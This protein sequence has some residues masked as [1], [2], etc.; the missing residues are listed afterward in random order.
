MDQRATDKPEQVLKFAPKAHASDSRLDE[1]G[2]AIVTQIQRAADLANEDCDRAMSLAHKLSMELRASE[3]QTHQC[4]PRL[5]SGAT[6]QPAPNN[7]FGSFR[8]RS[9]KS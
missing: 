8:K 2:K 3:D 9:R 1:A 6:E 7:G 5:N 4:R